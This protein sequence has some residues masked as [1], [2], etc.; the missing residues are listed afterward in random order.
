MYQLGKTHGKVHGDILTGHCGRPKCKIW[1]HLSIQ[2]QILS[3][4]THQLT[5]NFLACKVSL[6]TAKLIFKLQ[7]LIGHI[8]PITYQMNPTIGGDGY[9][10]F[11]GQASA[12]STTSDDNNKLEFKLHRI[13]LITQSNPV[14]NS[15]IITKS[16]RVTNSNPT[17]NANSYCS[18]A[19]NLDNMCHFLQ[20]QPF[21]RLYLPKREQQ[22]SSFL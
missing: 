16:I 3:T 1:G 10:S 14:A 11:T 7:A 8:D 22:K 19:S 6:Q 18:R 15:Y 12:W 13:K 20:L 4:A 17:I 2:R 21:Y 5:C 9:Y